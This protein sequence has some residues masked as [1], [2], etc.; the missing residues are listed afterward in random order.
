M[1]A[2]NIS[3]LRWNPLIVGVNSTVQITGSRVGGFLPTVTGTAALVRRNE[4]G[5]TT[6]IFTGLAVT[7][8]VWVD[9][10]F[11][12]SSHGGTFTTAGGA[13]GVLAV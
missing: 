6:T 12:L 9:I 4:D 13:A 1:G 7:A 2:G 10:P 11:Y 3:Q 8:G 5:T